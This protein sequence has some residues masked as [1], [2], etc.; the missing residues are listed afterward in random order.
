MKRHPWDFFVKGKPKKFYHKRVRGKVH[1]EKCD[2]SGNED[3]WTLYTKGTFDYISFTS[4]DSML[5]TEG[6][7]EIYRT[8]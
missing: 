1:F 2:L 7:F 3:K 8:H 6:Y 5:I 4:S